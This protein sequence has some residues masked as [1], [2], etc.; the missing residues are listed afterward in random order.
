[1][2]EFWVYVLKKSS[3]RDKL[4][5]IGEHLA[6][7]RALFHVASGERWTRMKV[8][9][10]ELSQCRKAFRLVASFP[11]FVRCHE[12]FVDFVMKPDIDVSKRLQLLL[13]AAG[14]FSSGMYSVY[15]NV[16]WAI[17][18]GLL[19]GAAIPAPLATFA[20]AKRNEQ[21]GVSAP[22]HWQQAQRWALVQ[23]MWSSM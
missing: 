9:E 20:V 4:L 7:A 16:D 17:S 6:R 1:M 13:E 14:N 2:S 3:G 11:D 8:V 15:D 19:R 5:A 23:C 18:V 10:S 22:F 21:V 12:A